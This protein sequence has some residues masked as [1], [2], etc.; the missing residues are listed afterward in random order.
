ML[1]SLLTLNSLFLTCA[2]EKSRIVELLKHR[3]TH[4]RAD[5]IAATY[6][7]AGSKVH[8]SSFTFLEIQYALENPLGQAPSYLGT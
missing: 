7:H 4:V 3:I 6:N 8:R 5:V 2:G 1:H